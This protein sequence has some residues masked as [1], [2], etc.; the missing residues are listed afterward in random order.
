MEVVVGRHVGQSQDGLFG[1]A[2]AL[3]QCELKTP[4]TPDHAVFHGVQL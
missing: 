1:D 3:P 2:G 4:V